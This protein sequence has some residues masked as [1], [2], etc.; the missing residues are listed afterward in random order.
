MRWVCAF[1]SGILLSGCLTSSPKHQLDVDRDADGFRV[2]LTNYSSKNLCL[3]EA[4]WPNA[5]GYTGDVQGTPVLRIGGSDHAYAKR[6]S[7]IGHLARLKVIPSGET[8][9]LK[10][11]AGD[12]ENVDTIP[13]Y[14]ELIFE[15]EP[16]SCTE[17][18]H[19][20]QP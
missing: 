7:A 16:V 3:M 2:G 9:S 1:L 19:S 13:D 10:L 11:T 8:L 6:F 5:D 17:R 12:F 15:P 20:K 18:A 14:A 4:I